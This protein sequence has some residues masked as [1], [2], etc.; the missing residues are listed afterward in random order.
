[1][2]KLTRRH[3]VATLAAALPMLTMPRKMVARANGTRAL[4]FAHTHTGERLVVEYFEGGAY[5]P[6]ALASVNRFLPES[7]GGSYVA[8]DYWGKK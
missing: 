7:L 6:D 8:T 4:R 1:M 2:H 5:L 3:F